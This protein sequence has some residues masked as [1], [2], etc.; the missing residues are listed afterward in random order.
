MQAHAVPHAE[1]RRLTRAEYDRM[2]ELGFFHGERVELVHGTI[3][4]MPPIGPPHANPVD[5][6]TE[7]LVRGVGARARVRIQQPYLAVDESE[8]EPDV[9]V[10]P[11]ASYANRHPDT[12]LLVIEVAETSLAY[13]REAKA[14]LYAASSVEEYWIVDVVARAV[15]I[16]RAPVAGRFS[17]ITRVELGGRVAPQRFEDLSLA[18]GDLFA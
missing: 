10:V 2:V 18:V 5:V 7:W 15:E 8:P 13:D 12:A 14:P 4:R 17:D 1:P 6:L 3:V 11:R 16:Y 9:A